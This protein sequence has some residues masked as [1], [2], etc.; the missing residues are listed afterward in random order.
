[1]T[2]AEQRPTLRRTAL[3]GLAVAA[4][5]LTAACGSSSGNDTSAASAGASAGS[6]SSTGGTA[7]ADGAANAFAPGSTVDNASIKKMFTDATSGA[8]TVHVEMK[9]SGQIAMSGGGDMDMKSNP[10]KADLRLTSASLGGSAIHMLMLDNTAYVKVPQLA[11]KYLKASLVGKNSALGQ[12]GLS[13]LDPSAM[14]DRFSDAISGGTYVGKETVDGTATDR[15]RLTVDAKAIAS[16][17]PSIS[18]Q[19]T[20]V[21]DTETV[22]VWF[23]GDGRYKQ[24]KT[25][26]GSETVSES[27]SDWGK[28]VT[29]KAPPASQVQ[30]MPSAAGGMLGG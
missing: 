15:Y 16:A 4:L 28:P 24:M 30:D 6:T 17:M 29:V 9:M 3:A 2:K 27:F 10:V 25:V 8:T 22:D 12:M 20:A 26:V 7:A 19:A 21:P 18:A 11:D 14:F 23:D 1:M 5:G 13:S